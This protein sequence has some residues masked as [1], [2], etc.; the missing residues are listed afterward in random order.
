MRKKVCGR[1]YSGLEYIKVKKL[2]GCEKMQKWAIKG[3]KDG[4]WILWNNFTGTYA[5]AKEK[6]ANLLVLLKYSGIMVEKV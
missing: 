6:A 5:E 2:D 3:Y 4:N 1:N